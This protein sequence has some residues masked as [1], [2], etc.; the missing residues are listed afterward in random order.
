LLKHKP[1]VVF[2][3]A[4]EQYALRAIKACAVDFL[5]KPIDI[6]ELKSVEEKLQQLRRL[7]ENFVFKSGYDQS[8][9]HLSGML[10][11]KEPLRTITIPDTSGYQIVSTDNILYLEGKD[12]YTFIYISGQNRMIVSRTLKDFETILQDSDFLRIHKSSMINLRHLKSMRQKEGLS[13]V[14]A[15]G[16]E[17][18]VS[19]RRG[20]SLM[21]RARAF[22]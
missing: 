11:L 4:H 5:L 8:L 9:A 17:F 2:V 13:V 6:N 12:N 10:R 14:M 21:E 20:N 3:T 18:P 16:K 7:S 1:H 22:L 15:D 19:R